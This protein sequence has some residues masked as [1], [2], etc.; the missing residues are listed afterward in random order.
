MKMLLLVVRNDQPSDFAGAVPSII[1]A[2][3]HHLHVK[4]GDLWDL[5]QFSAPSQKQLFS[6]SHEIVE[7]NRCFRERAQGNWQPQ[8]PRIVISLS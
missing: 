7:D 3:H 8:F 1:F 6:G 2:F 5:L 4:C